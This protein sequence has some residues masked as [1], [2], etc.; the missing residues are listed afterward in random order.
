MKLK[1]AIKSYQNKKGV[2]RVIDKNGVVVREH[3]TDGHSIDFV[4]AEWAIKC[5]EMKAP[6][7]YNP[8]GAAN[9]S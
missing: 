6:S 4:S 2:V 1:Q 9:F 5:G 8:E 3:Q 7:Y